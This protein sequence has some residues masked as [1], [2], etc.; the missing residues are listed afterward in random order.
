MG[1][2][3]IDIGVGELISTRRQGITGEAQSLK[4]I[5][6]DFVIEAEMRV[7]IAIVPTEEAKPTRKNSEGLS[8][9]LAHSYFRSISTYDLPYG[10]QRRKRLS[11]FYTRW[12]VIMCW[13]GD[14]LVTLTMQGH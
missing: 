7:G 9:R 2:Y 6:E 14:E 10:V 3:G 13:S 12:L 11:P 4:I 1:E 8:I 5:R